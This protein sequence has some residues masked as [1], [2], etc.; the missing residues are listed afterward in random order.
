MDLFTTQY[1]PYL[2]MDISR[3]LCS[4][5]GYWDEFS[6]GASPKMLWNSFYNQGAVP[7][8]GML[9]SIPSMQ[10]SLDF[11]NTHSMKFLKELFYGGFD[12]FR[13]HMGFYMLDP[14][15]GGQKLKTIS[16]MTPDYMGMPSTESARWLNTML[17][18]QGGFNGTDNNIM[19]DLVRVP[20]SL[21]KA[22][23]ADGSQFFTNP[24]SLGVSLSEVIFM[25][26]SADTVTNYFNTSPNVFRAPQST[27]ESNAGGNADNA[28]SEE[29]TF[30]ALAYYRDLDISACNGYFSTDVWDKWMTDLNLSQLMSS[31]T[32]GGSIFYQ[33]NLAFRLW[34]IN[35]LFNNEVIG[36]EHNLE[37]FDS[38]PSTLTMVDG[39]AGSTGAVWDTSWLCETNE[40]G[41]P[42]LKPYPVWDSVLSDQYAQWPADFKSA[43][44]SH[45]NGTYLGAG[46]LAYSKFT[47]QKM[48]FNLDAVMGD[49]NYSYIDHHF[50]WFD[51]FDSAQGASLADSVPDS[52]LSYYD[53]SS[54]YSY[55]LPSWE[56]A[57]VVLSNQWESYKTDTGKYAGIP[58]EL[59]LPNF[60]ITLEETQTSWDVTHG[61]SKKIPEWIHSTLAQRLQEENGNAILRYE[62]N[63]DGTENYV[64][65]NEYFFDWQKVFLADPF[66]IFEDPTFL[67]TV[68]KNQNIMLSPEVLRNR[69]DIDENKHAFP[70]YVEFELKGPPNHLFGNILAETGIMPFFLMDA[71][72]TLKQEGTA[73][74]K[75]SFEAAVANTAI[76]KI[77]VVPNNYNQSFVQNK[78]IS[79]PFSKY[80]GGNIQ[81]QEYDNFWTEMYNVDYFIT[82]MVGDNATLSGDDYISN[83]KND[84]YDNYFYITSGEE[85]YDEDSIDILASSA[86]SLTQIVSLQHM[87]GGLSLEKLRPHAHTCSGVPAY[88]EVVFFEVKKYKSFG[89]AKKLIQTFILPNVSNPD[90]GEQGSQAGN[91]LKFV[92]SQVLPGV[93]YDYEIDAY[94]YVLGSS[95]SYEIKGKRAAPAAETISDGGEEWAGTGWGESKSFDAPD[96]PNFDD[97]AE[98]ESESDI[99]FLATGDKSTGHHAQINLH[100][101]TKPSHKLMKIPFGKTTAPV[102]IVDSPP[103]TPQVDIVPYRARGNKIYIALNTGAD[104]IYDYPQ[105]ITREE[106]NVIYDDAQYSQDVDLDK[107]T[108]LSGMATLF[109]GDANAS[110]P[111]GPGKVRFKSDG[112]VYAFEAYRI[113]EEDMPYGPRN[114]FDFGSSVAKKTTLIRECRTTFIDDVKPNVNYYY[115]FR[116]LDKERAGIENRGWSNPTDIYRVKLVKSRDNVYLDIETQPKEYFKAQT[117]IKD[118][119]PTKPFKK[120]LMIR[121]AL[122]QSVLNTDPENGGVDY[123]DE[124]IYT[125]YKDFFL[126]NKQ[127]AENME[128]PGISIEKPLGMSSISVWGTVPPGASSTTQNGGKFR[129]RIKSK[130]TGKKVDIILGINKP[131]IIDNTGMTGESCEATAAE[132]PS[133]STTSDYK[134]TS[135]ELEEDMF[136]GSGGDPG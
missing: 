123:W 36:T 104:D 74:N 25:K 46:S 113:S 18:E 65:N 4:H 80:Q 115:I 97:A 95:Y 27:F 28:G 72:A 133:T 112:D 52:S 63:S 55:Y 64:A 48:A 77:S 98:V 87:L 17:L 103:I 88:S 13:Y 37:G 107:Y 26:T 57:I 96:G 1:I 50:E 71:C 111:F 14:T 119:I 10:E 66:S 22:G 23:G 101:D 6:S 131:K 49:S 116:V 16:G 9:M 120:Y 73:A 59:F 132:E 81:S 56:N 19:D 102:R 12:L 32:Q 89:G 39:L 92:D 60:H 61:T 91:V 125:S 121:P 35:Y 45:L 79:L 108:V 135:E 41:I 118:H 90:D 114:I 24:N 51:P 83:I 70:F 75:A 106:Q 40:S 44:I 110:F 68:K 122:E 58:F 76:P 126:G 84:H 134:P 21:V 78:L 3:D 7:N 11:S 94:N 128:Y 117:R 67:A 54:V 105:G 15:V 53:I 130:H 127:E 124:N 5:I 29:T 47:P 30:G 129:V 82:T 136:G 2:I 86:L 99:I 20:F 8:T 34:L 42:K 33:S 38:T 31:Q 43:A 85:D 62:V 100:I 109:G 93:D 69:V